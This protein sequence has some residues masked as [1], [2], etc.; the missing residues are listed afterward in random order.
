[1]KKINVKSKS[2]EFISILDKQFNGTLILARIKLIAMF[3][4]AGIS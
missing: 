1:M 2:T 4:C 3:I